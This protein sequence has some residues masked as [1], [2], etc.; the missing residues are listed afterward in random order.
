MAWRSDTDSGCVHGGQELVLQEEGI[1][2]IETLGRLCP[3]L[4]ILYMPNNLI[5][6]LENLNR[7][8]A[9]EYLNLAINNITKLDGLEGCEMLNKLDMT[10]NFVDQEGLITATKLRANIHLKELYL[11]GNPCTDYPGYRKFVIAAVPSLQLLDAHKIKPSERIAAQQEFH[12]LCAE[13]LD[14]CTAQPVANVSTSEQELPQLN[15]KGEVVRDYTVANRV[16]E[17][18]EMQQIRE[19]QENKSKPKTEERKS[20]RRAGFD[21]LPCEGRTY[22]KNEGSLDFKLVESDCGRHV[23]CDVAVGRYLDTSLIDVDIQPSWIRIL[24]KGKL[25]Q[26]RLPCEVKSDE[27][28]IQRSAT[29]GRLLV[30][31]PKVVSDPRW[32][33]VYSAASAL[34]HIRSKTNKFVDTTRT[35]REN[36]V[37]PSAAVDIHD[38]VIDATP[39][40][41]QGD[42][43]ITQRE[44][45]R[46][47]MTEH[48]AKVME[49]E[50]SEDQELSFNWEDDIPALE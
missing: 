1:D 33:D 27:S 8:K 11:S 37:E 43:V 38:I 30:T 20:R 4:K 18:N 5:P 41:K 47:K 23:L 45:Q 40:A 26:L 28:I 3:N 39:T 22:Q 32:K 34:P 6:R 19:E 9:L 44:P 25:L 14:S 24:V 13:V 31:M 36:C 42:A 48:D 50:K 2:K 12:L 21:P 29:T 7:L 49:T 17:H 46:A 16:K 15:E 10:L 35:R